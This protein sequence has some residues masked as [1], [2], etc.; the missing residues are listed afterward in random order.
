MKR[1]MLL[2]G[3]VILLLAA[4]WV[5]AAAGGSELPWF[6]V[7]GGGGESSGGPYAMAGS[8]GQPDAGEMGG[9]AYALS[10]GYLAVAQQGAISPPS[11]SDYVF[12][13]VTI[14]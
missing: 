7:D 14:R 4:A 5:A 8:I 11:Y 13:P 9:G 12:L 6:S 1:W 10:G 2:C 3:I